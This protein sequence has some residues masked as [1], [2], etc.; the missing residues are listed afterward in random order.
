MACL[1]LLLFR[2]PPSP[3]GQASSHG[4]RVLARLP[5][6]EVSN[7]VTPKTGF[8]PRARQGK[9]SCPGTEADP[10]RTTTFLAVAPPS[11]AKPL[12]TST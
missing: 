2:A 9:P 6:L 10:S 7:T 11:G 8:S 3:G 12:A 1:L 4:N 5:G